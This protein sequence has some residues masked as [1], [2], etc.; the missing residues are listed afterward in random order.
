MNAKSFNAWLE[1]RTE[2]Q[3]KLIFGAIAAMV[4]LG[5]LIFVIQAG[6]LTAILSLSLGWLL[7][8]LV[9]LAIFAAFS[10][11]V[12]TQAPQQLC[13]DLHTTSSIDG[14]VEIQIAPSLAAAWTFALGSRDSDQSIP[15][16]I[17]NLALVVPRLFWT[18]T[19]LKQRAEDVRQTE[20]ENCGRVLRMLLKK[21]ERVEVQEIAEKYPDMD[22]VPLIRQLSL[23]DGVV[24]LTK[25]SVGLTLANRFKDDL[26]TAASALETANQPE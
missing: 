21:A 19:W 12:W 5:I 15:E 10:A 1:Q 4:A 13:D 24:F 8:F 17:F 18:T 14:D 3:V 6:L 23:I 2:L 9:V 20:I 26:E 7:G 22:L 11:F 16:R 25:K